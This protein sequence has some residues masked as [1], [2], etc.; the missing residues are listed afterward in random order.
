MIL[1]IVL[2]ESRLKKVKA[3]SWGKTIYPRVMDPSSM[4]YNPLILFVNLCQQ[5]FLS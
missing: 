2:V 4:A 3:V 1:F 5:V